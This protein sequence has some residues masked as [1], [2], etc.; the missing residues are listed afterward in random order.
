MHPYSISTRKDAS[1]ISKD[2]SYVPNLLCEQ[3]HLVEDISTVLKAW[4]QLH[5]VLYLWQL[6]TNVALYRDVVF[7]SHG[8]QSL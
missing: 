8:A 2:F 5:R 3:A 6:L 4:E 1:R 7:R